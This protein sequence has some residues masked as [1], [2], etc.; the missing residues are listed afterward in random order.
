MFERPDAETIRM[1]E[2]YGTLLAFLADLDEQA[3]IMAREAPHP[4]T[5][6]ILTAVRLQM[7]SLGLVVSLAARSAP[8]RDRKG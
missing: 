3:E 2:P 6:E 4:F 1:P 5:A 8:A 7:A